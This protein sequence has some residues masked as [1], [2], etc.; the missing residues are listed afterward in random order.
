MDKRDI[1]S[2]IEEKRAL[3]IDVNDR[4]WDTPETAFQEYRSMDILCE[5]LQNEGFEVEKGIAGIDTAFRARF[6]SGKPVIGILGEFDALAGL[7]QMAGSAEKKEL[8]AGGNGH[9]CGHNSLGAGSLAAAVAVK[10]YL[11]ENRKTGTV[12]YFGC[13]GEEGGSGKVFMAREG[14]FDE[15]DIALTWHPSNVNV[16]LPTQTLANYQI[17]YKFYGV[18]AHAAAHPHHGR[19]ALDAVELMNVGV[20]FLREHMIPEARIHYAITNTGGYSPNVVQA[21]AEVLY[22]IRSPKT[23]E[24]QELYERVNKIAEGAALMTETRCERVFIKA[25]S[26]VVANDTLDRMIHE[27]MMQIGAPQYDTEELRF[28]AAIVKSI[29]QKSPDFEEVAKL[30]GETGEKLLKENKGK[31]IYDIV[32]PFIDTVKASPSSTDVGDVSYICPIGKMFTA[33]GAGGTPAHSWQ[34]VA[35][36]KSSIAHKGMLLAGKVLAATAVD[37]LESPGLVEEAKKELET[38]LGGKKYQCPIPQGVKPFIIKMR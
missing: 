24:V 5:A 9:G 21:E 36:G 4:I 16:V 8:A 35:Q 27:N 34:F 28:A 17:S 25:C 22:L 12:I 13:P 31:Y 33:T 7:S 26:D 20:N 32:F 29:A 23:A 11:Q 2:Y 30:L 3:F 14:V 6:G 38:R 18:S 1:A 19:S 15:L 10:E 37:L